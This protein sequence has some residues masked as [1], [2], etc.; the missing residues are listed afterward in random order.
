M[1]TLGFT[2]LVGRRRPGAQHFVLVAEPRVVSVIVGG[3]GQVPRLRFLLETWGKL[4]TL[5]LATRYNLC[6]GKTNQTGVLWWNGAL[7]RSLRKRGVSEC[8]PL[9]VQSAQA[10]GTVTDAGSYCVVP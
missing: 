8:G 7:D 6:T 5:G 10:A 3:L 4:E 9:S 1:G 2:N